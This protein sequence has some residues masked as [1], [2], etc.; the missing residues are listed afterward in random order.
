[1]RDMGSIATLHSVLFTFL[2]LS[3]L[4]PK[5]VLAYEGHSALP[6]ALD[7]VYGVGIALLSF[8]LGELRRR[9]PT[10]NEWYFEKNVILV[11]FDVVT[12]LLKAARSRAAS[13]QLSNDPH[14]SHY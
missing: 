14:D 10:G 3:L 11:V 6:N 8:W 7:L 1:M 2:T 13:C 5:A 4:L 12:A 9:Y